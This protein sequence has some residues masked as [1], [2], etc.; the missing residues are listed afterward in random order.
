MNISIGTITLYFLLLIFWI[1]IGYCV[2]RKRVCGA[3]VGVMWTLLFGIVGLA[4]IL[5]LYPFKEEVPKD[6]M[7]DAN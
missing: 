1:I 7:D 3:G 5:A 2:G 6:G 4:I